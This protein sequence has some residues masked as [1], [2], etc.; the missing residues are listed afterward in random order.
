MRLQAGDVLI[1]C[2]EVRTITPIQEM[3]EGLVLSGPKNLETLRDI[4]DEVEQRKTQVQDD[5]HQLFTQFVSVMGGY[6]LAVNEHETADT[7][8][9]W[10]APS[11]LENLQKQGVTDTDTRAACLQVWQDSCEIMANLSCNLRLFEEVENFLQDWLWGLA[12]QTIRWQDEPGVPTIG[13]KPL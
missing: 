3:V 12:Y 1:R 9:N 5:L 13:E 6:G 8:Q 7:V 2:L 10:T 4:L 11:L